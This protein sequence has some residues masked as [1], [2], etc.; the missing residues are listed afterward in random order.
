MASALSIDNMNRRNGW[1]H[2]MTSS[3]HYKNAVFIIL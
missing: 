3:S 2:V 1:L